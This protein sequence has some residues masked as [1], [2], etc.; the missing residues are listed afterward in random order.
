[1]SHPRSRPHSPQGEGHASHAAGL[2]HLANPRVGPRADRS[3]ARPAARHSP[4]HNPRPRTAPT[5]ASCGPRPGET[6]SP[7]G[8]QPGHRPPAWSTPTAVNVDAAMSS[9]TERSSAV[10]SVEA[11]TNGPGS[12][13][14]SWGSTEKPSLASTSPRRQCG[15]DT[16]A[17]ISLTGTAPSAP[18][19]ASP[20]TSP[21]RAAHEDMT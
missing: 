19:V 9:D 20:S 21:C 13:T 16:Y 17:G 18:S 5:A 15:C 4:R 2:P 3:S 7:F 10:R 6:A 8:N 11:R 1:M 12:A 14:E